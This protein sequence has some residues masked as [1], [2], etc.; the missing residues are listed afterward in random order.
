MDRIEPSKPLT[1]VV[2]TT[3]KNILE[4]TSRIKEL[5]ILK[6]RVEKIPQF[7]NNK[8]VLS[9]ISFWFTKNAQ[10]EYFL[11]YSKSPSEWDLES[12]KIE[13]YQKEYELLMQ[14]N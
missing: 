4:L 2:L 7:E 10:N 12:L 1:K 14:L 13:L 5:L 8:T 11:I 9:G 3:D 6:G